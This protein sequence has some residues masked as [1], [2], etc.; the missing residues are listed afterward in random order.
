VYSGA[1]GNE[2]SFK[3]L[4]G[5]KYSILH[6]ATHGFFIEDIEKKHDERELLQRV[7]GGQKAFENPLLRSGLILSGGNLAWTN[8]TVADVEDGILFADE[9]ARLNLLGTELVV[10]SACETAL[11][12]VNNSEGVFGLQRAFKLAGVETL[13]MSLWQVDDQAT[14]L[15]MEQFYQNWLSGKSKQEA[16]KEARKSLRAEYESPFYWAAFV[17]MDGGDIQPAKNRSINM[18]LILGILIVG[19]SILIIVCVTA[20]RKHQILRRP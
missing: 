1:K 7:G 17:L 11:G 15:L 4:N 16:M 19:L 10:L 6:L 2:E 9:V 12:E 20:W 14:M 18:Y 3:A 8:N 5:K 13:I